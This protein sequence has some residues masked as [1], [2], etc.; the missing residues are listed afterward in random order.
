MQ[1]SFVEEPTHC[2]TCNGIELIW[3]ELRN[4]WIAPYVDGGVYCD[5]S[6]NVEEVKNSLKIPLKRG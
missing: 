6:D 5:C 2:P 4:R 1:A 3:D